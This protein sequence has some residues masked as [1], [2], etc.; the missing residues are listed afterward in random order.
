VQIRDALLTEAERD[1]GVMS[2]QVVEPA[3]GWAADRG[4]D[5]VVIVEVEPAGSA[6]TGASQTPH[7]PTQGRFLGFPGF[8]KRFMIIPCRAD[9]WPSGPN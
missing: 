1:L 5:A 3:D 2:R 4:V 6:W 8:R 7:P 9:I